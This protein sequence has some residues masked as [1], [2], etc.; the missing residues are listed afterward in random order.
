MQIPVSAIESLT[1]E[2]NKLSKDE[3]KGIIDKKLHGKF[4][5]YR[6]YLR[7][8]TDKDLSFSRIKYFNTTHNN[9]KHEILKNITLYEK[10]KRH[11]ARRAI[12]WGVI[13]G[14]LLTLYFVPISIAHSKN[15]NE[16][17]WDNIEKLSFKKRHLF[18]GEEIETYIL[19]H[20]KHKVKSI[21]F[22]DVHFEN[23][24]RFNLTIPVT[25]K[26]L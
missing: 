6:L 26:E 9:N 16:K 17:L 11:T 20:K 7:N 1:Y 15:M 2:L 21:T 13:G 5:P 8:N 10:T 19:I 22:K 4:K 23:D 25:A 24:K 14:G 18:A 3:S 12:V